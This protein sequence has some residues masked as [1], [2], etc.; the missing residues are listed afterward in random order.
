MVLPNTILQEEGEIYEISQK[1]L[2]KIP[3]I[4]VAGKEYEQDLPEIGLQKGQ[5]Y[6]E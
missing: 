4:V 3:L 2:K 6:L 5:G 1:Y